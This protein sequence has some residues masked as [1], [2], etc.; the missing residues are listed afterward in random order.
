MVASTIGDKNVFLEDGITLKIS[1]SDSSVQS[2]CRSV[3]PLTNLFIN[4]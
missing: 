1:V 3:F 2:E 4:K